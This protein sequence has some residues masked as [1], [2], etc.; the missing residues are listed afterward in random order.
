M[1][2][3]ALVSAGENKQEKLVELLLKS[4]AQYLKHPMKHEYSMPILYSLL[5]PQQEIALVKTIIVTT[6]LDLIH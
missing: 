3:V 4:T 2:A 5:I 6:T 1:V